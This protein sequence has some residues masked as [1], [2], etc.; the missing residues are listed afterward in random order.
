MARNVLGNN[1]IADL[2]FG[3]KRIVTIFADW[4]KTHDRQ[5]AA[6]EKELAELRVVANQVPALTKRVN[7][8][9]QL[10][11]NVETAVEDA[12]RLVEAKQ[13]M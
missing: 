6:M 12:L 13:P 3:I 10:D 7:G 1:E 11:L 8:L 9:E 4:L 2:H 5:I